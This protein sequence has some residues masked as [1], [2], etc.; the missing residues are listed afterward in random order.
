M[1]IYPPTTVA[2]NCFE[3]VMIICSMLVVVV[4]MDD[5]IILIMYVNDRGFK[6]EWNNFDQ[7]L[8][9]VVLNR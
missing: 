7:I 3:I 2:Y 1:L 6:Q 5:E 4:L 8:E 9:I